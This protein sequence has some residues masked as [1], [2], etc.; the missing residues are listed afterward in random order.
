MKKLIPFLVATTMLLSTTAAAQV[1]AQT[2]PAASKTM[3]I[4][5]MV[6]DDGRTMVAKNARSWSI[7]NPTMLAGREGHRVRIKCRVYP[8]SSNILVLSVK[9]T[10]TQT[11]Y[12]ANP[13]DSAFRR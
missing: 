1:H 4:F 7:T 6:S 9:L 8:N 3:T 11:R 2:P 13:S 12:A 5:G 10:D